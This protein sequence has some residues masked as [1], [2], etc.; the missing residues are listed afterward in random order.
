ME[1]IVAAGTGHRPDKL[2]GYSDSVFYALVGLARDGIT[3]LRDTYGVN[4]IV[5]GMALGWDQALATAAK[6]LGVP[7]VAAIPFK[8]QERAWPQ[9]SQDRYN[10]LLGKAKRVI[11]VCEGGYAGWKMQR[12]NEA[13]VDEAAIILALWNGSSGG[14]ANCLSYATD[15]GLLVINLWDK[16]TRLGK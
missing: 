10:H 3:E 8:G 7:F 13:M 4:G 12:R 6:T 9:E 11:T 1:W 14:T 5:S 15:K 16:W 2:G